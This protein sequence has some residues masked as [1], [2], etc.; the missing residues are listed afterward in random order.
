M[1]M[2]TRVSALLSLKPEHY[3]M[4]EMKSAKTNDANLWATETMNNP[5]P[6]IPMSCSSVS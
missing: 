3:R 5:K 2:R 4:A 1:K 6:S